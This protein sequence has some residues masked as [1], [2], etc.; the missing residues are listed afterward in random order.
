M[1]KRTNLVYLDN[2]AT[3]QTHPCVI[4]E[5]TKWM[6]SINNPSTDN[7]LSEP[8]KQLLLFAQEYILK[9]CK[10]SI[11]DYTVIFTSSGCES[12]S[13]I[14]RSTVAAYRVKYN[15]KPHIITS[16][17]EHKGIIDTINCLYNEG[18]LTYTMIPPNAEGII[19]PKLVESAIK[20][21]TCLIS[22]MYANNEIGSINDIYSIAKIAERHNIPYHTDAV[23]MFGKVAVNMNGLTALSASFHKFNAGN[24]IGLLIIKNSFIES[25]KLKGIINGSQQHRLRGGTES[26]AIIAGALKGLINNFHKR[27]EKNKKLSDLRTYMLDKLSSYIPIVYYTKYEQYIRSQNIMIV[28]F[29]PEVSQVN[30]YIP[31]TLLITV[32]IKDHDICN[33]LLKKELEKYGVIV[34]IGSACNTSSSN[35]SH[36]IRALKVN[37][38]LKK[39]VLR[40]SF[41]DFNIKTDVDKFIK[42]FLISL[43]KQVQLNSLLE[44]QIRFLNKK[45]RFNP[46]IENI[47]TDKKPNI[48]RK[49]VIKSILKKC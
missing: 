30:K 3:T 25:Y 16:E 41:G 15:T 33:V 1:N 28:L 9:H 32:Y 47:L 2:S 6:K 21:N 4:Q 39:G 17:I 48:I 37:D 34:S 5:I 40:I 49:E 19:D 46:H 10:V 26:T 20:K 42:I 18:C 12:N 35:A 38:K 7:F 13:F 44:K 14:I 24:G 31:N 8:S 29:G 23:Q 22:I 11:N 45:I 43:N 27:N 36:V